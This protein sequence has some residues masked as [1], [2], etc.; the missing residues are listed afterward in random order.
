MRV[1]ID[2][3][4][5]ISGLLWQGLPWRLLRL[6]EQGRVELCLSYAMLQELSEVLA[7]PKLKPRLEALGVSLAELEA[8]VMS[9]AQ[10]FDAPDSD[11]I[12][13]TADPDD[14]IILHCAVS[15]DVGYIVSGDHHLLDLSKYGSIPIISINE[16][17]ALEFPERQ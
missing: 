9:L 16:F 3:N 2:T 17:F 11:E 14:D 10:F 6:A 13:V 1:V 8:F 5:W 12:I 15:A 7:Y 4:I